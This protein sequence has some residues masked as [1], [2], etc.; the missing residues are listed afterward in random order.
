MSEATPPCSTECCKS[1]GCPNKRSEGRFEGDI[2]SPCHFAQDRLSKA[3]AAGGFTLGAI[4]NWNAGLANCAAAGMERANLLIAVLKGTPCT[5]MTSGTYSFPPSP[6][7]HSV[8]HWCGRCR[9]LG[10]SDTNPEPR[11][12]LFPGQMIV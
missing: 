4:E 8:K 12:H 3:A 7:D 11:P 1:P 9:A 6:S 2:C 10:Y 5:C